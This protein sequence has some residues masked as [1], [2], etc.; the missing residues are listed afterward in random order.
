MVSELDTLLGHDHP[1][2]HR[3]RPDPHRRRWRLLRRRRRAQHEHNAPQCAGLALRHAPG[4]PHRARPARPGPAGHRGRGR[5]RVRRR[6][7]AGAAGRHRA[8]LQPRAFLHGLRARGAGARLRRPV[9]TAPGGRPATCQGAG[10]LGPRGG[11]RRSPHTG[12]GAG[13]PPPG[14]S[15][16]PCRR[17]GPGPGGRV[18]AR[19]GHHQGQRTRDRSAQIPSRCSTSA[20]SCCRATASRC[21]STPAAPTWNCRRWPASAGPSRPGQVRAGRRRDHRHRHGVGHA[22]HGG[23]VDSGI[24]AGSIRAMGL[25]KMLRAQELALENKLPFV[26]L[27]ESAGANLLPTRSRLSCAAA[28]VPQPGALS[29][30]GLPVVTVCTVRPPPAAPTRPACRTT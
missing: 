13:S 12:P 28:P 20:A 3:P 17:T 26:Q 15:A 23:G 14:A 24:E 16:G 5:R 7:L 27:V 9:H 10:V 29:A 2:R 4:A 21:C 18:T 30:A 8:G 6:F 25:E 22:L 11:R 19:H 1:R